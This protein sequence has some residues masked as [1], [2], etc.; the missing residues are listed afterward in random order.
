MN[1]DS[2]TL[3][4]NYILVNSSRIKSS[5]ATTDT[6]I[7]FTVTYYAQLPQLGQHAYRCVAP[8]SIHSKQRIM[9]YACLAFAVITNTN[10][11]CQH[12]CLES[13]PWGLNRSQLSFVVPL[14]VKNTCQGSIMKGQQTNEHS[15][16]WFSKNPFR[17][18]GQIKHWGIE[19]TNHN[20]RLC[21]SQAHVSIYHSTSLDKNIFLVKEETILKFQW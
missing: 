17:S 2:A 5:Q 10:Y 12:S 1:S 9:L 6:D 4:A 18:P 11:T 19:S 21:V 14:S 3:L 8:G 13:L 15:S 7:H 20:W 16:H